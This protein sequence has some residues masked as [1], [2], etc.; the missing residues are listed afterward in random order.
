MELPD[1]DKQIGK[2]D[3]IAVIESVKAA[4]DI[5]SPV[6]GRIIEVNEDLNE[7]PEKVNSNP[8]GEGWIFKLELTDESEID[9]LMNESS[10]NNYINISSQ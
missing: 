5:K 1:L 8:Q 7:E 10:Y 6:R 4:S 2:D 9:Q 3:D